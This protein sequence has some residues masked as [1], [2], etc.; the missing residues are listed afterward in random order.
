M[1]PIQRETITKLNGRNVERGTVLSFKGTRGRFRF[2][3]LDT[4]L[5]TGEQ[6]LTVYGGDRNA[7]GHQSWRSFPLE[8]LRTVHRNPAH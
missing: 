1:P 5:S 7:L 8:K 3:S 4:N 2:Q 6:W